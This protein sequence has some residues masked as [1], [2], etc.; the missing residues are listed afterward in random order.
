MELARIVG[1]VTATLKDGSLQGVKLALVQR[2]DADA[3]AIGAVEVAVDTQSVGDG[4][5]VLVARGSA[6]RQP[7]IARGVPSDLTIVAIVD[8]LNVKPAKRS[9]PDAPAS[10]SRK[11]ASSASTGSTR[12]T[13]RTRNG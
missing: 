12:S 2:V 13:G 11:P 5:L 8:A 9:T 4:E 10:R 1:S 3:N 6:A 7:E